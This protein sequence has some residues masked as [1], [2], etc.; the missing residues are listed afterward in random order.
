MQKGSKIY[1]LEALSGDP[2][3]TRNTFLFAALTACGIPPEPELCGEFVEPI[4]GQEQ[5]RRTTVWRLKEKSVDGQYRT[6]DLIKLWLD[7]EFVTREPE[8]PL[9][10]LKAG[11]ENYS[12]SQE[13]LK[14]QGPIYVRR[15]GRK[16]A[17]ITRRTTE[18]NRKRII[19]ELAK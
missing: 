3:A 1:S 16:I 15:R 7:P 13:F 19:D 2:L 4:E 18:A 10:Y 5:P 12:R 9:A 6:K 17:L 8:H 14:E 11:F